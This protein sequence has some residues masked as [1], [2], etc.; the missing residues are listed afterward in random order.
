MAPFEDDAPSS[1]SSSLSVDELLQTPRMMLVS[2]LYNSGCSVPN[3]VWAD[4]E[5]IVGVKM[6]SDV[7][8]PWLCVDDDDSDEL[9]FVSDSIGDRQRLRS[10]R[11]SGVGELV[12]DRSEAV[13]ND[14]YDGVGLIRGLGYGVRLG[15]LLANAEN[16]V[17]GLVLRRC[18]I[19]EGV[20]ICDV[21]GAEMEIWLPSDNSPVKLSERGCVN[22]Y[23]SKQKKKP[24]RI[25]KSVIKKRV[26]SLTSKQQ[27][28]ITINYT[29]VTQ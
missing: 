20:R 17:A 2:R 13:N 8:D 21:V 29:T 4:V 22:Q 1:A 27:E 19:G 12:F 9:I 23:T 18:R 14:V 6:D 26:Q 24:V 11:D 3:G 16:V 5:L 15:L 25:R 7:V 10:I 28:I